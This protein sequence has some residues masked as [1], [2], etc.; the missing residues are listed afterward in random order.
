LLQKL[1]LDKKFT[2][3]AAVD[4][5]H[6]LPDED[7]KPFRAVLDVVL[8]RTTSGARVFAALK[9]AVD[10]GISIPHSP[11]RFSGF[12]RGKGGEK[13]D[14]EKFRKRLLGAHVASYLKSLFASDPE[15]AKRQFSRYFDLKVNAAQVEGL[16]VDVHK[17]IRADP[18]HVPTEKH[19][20]PVEQKAGR[21]V[22][23][24]AYKLK[25]GKKVRIHSPHLT[26]GERLAIR[27]QRRAAFRKR[28]A[29]AEEGAAAAKEDEGDE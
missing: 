18:K 13:L 15:A 6:F 29:E 8:A 1:D 23:R 16:W 12:E 9:G 17:K 25:D 26:T 21:E 3:V 11:S 4:G 20:P 24:F 7:T 28:K 5:K 22:K 14:S 27:D 2:G 10:G 19:A